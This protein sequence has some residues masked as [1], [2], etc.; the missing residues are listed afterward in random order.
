MPVDPAASLLTDPEA[1]ATSLLIL[2]VDRLGLDSLHWAPATLALELADALGVTPAPGNL[3]RLL[4]AMTIVTTDLF[5]KSLPHFIT[6]CNVLAGSPPSD[7]FDP[8]DAAECAWGITE[9]LLLSPPDEEE[10]PEPFSD[11]IRAYLGQAAKAE[12]LIELP[13]VLRIA[14][15]PQDYAAQVSYDFS[16]DP[17]MFQ[18]IWQEQQD[19]TAEINE[20][21]RSNLQQLATQVDSL[22]L[23]GRSGHLTAGSHLK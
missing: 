16:D 17:E 20:L 11:E 7:Q 23:E 2:T 13:D 10:D 22:P 8:A 6:L 14:L 19:K 5:F 4:A 12:G 15:T 18:G 3:D 9:A 1:Y 21:V